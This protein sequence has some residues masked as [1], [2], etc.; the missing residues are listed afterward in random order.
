MKPLQQEATGIPVKMDVGNS[1]FTITGSGG[2]FL[3][4]KRA[5]SDTA[6]ALKIDTL[7]SLYQ[8]EIGHDTEGKH[9]YYTPLVKHLRAL[10][11]KLKNEITHV[12]L[13]NYVLIIDEINRANISRVFGELITLLEKDKRLGNTHEMIVTLSNG[14]K[15]SV[16]K[17]LYIIGTMNTADKSIA[18]LDIALRRRFVFEDMYPRD[19]VIDELIPPPYNEFLKAVNQKIM[20]ERSADF[21]IGHAYFMADDD[22]KLDFEVIMNR[23]VIPLLNEYFYNAKSGFVFKLIADAINLVPGFIIEQDP[24]L[25]AVVKATS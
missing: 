9:I 16:P 23:Q 1:D 19:H 10:A 14:E 8:N 12:E 7:K 13:K 21:L 17:N 18:L 5:G 25:G 22:V 24:Y 6:E 3:E 11:E 20:I 15:F 2:D 4:F